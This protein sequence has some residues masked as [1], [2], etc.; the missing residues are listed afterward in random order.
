MIRLFV[1]QDLAA[2]GRVAVGGAQCHYLRN[3]MRRGPGD[4]I[5]LFNGRDG[6]WQGRITRIDKKVCE[7]AVEVERR[8]QASGPD[9]WLLF[10]P[11]K[12]ARLDF[13]AQKATELGV[14]GLQPVLTERTVVRRVK[15]DRI[16]ANAVEA[17]EQCGRLTV[18]DVTEPA[19]LD[20]VLQTWPT[21]R[22]LL[23]CDEAGAPPAL[24]QLQAAE[25][26][27]WALLIGPEG[28]FSPAERDRLADLDHVTRIGLGPH[29][30]RADTAVVAA[31]AL[32]QAVLGDWRA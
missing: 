9:L 11:V 6:E 3:V 28:G 27:P 8:P 24:A 10:A 5:A 22:R 12:A 14:S 21:G 26:G 31:L 17:A 7:L 29:I 4:E 15:T 2:A 23:V 20:D 18:P 16:R 1:D 30:L 19:S 25:A 13:V 32:W